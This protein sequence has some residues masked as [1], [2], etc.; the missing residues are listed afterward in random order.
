MT[1]Q[2]TDVFALSRAGTAYRAPISD[3]VTT[4]LAGLDYATVADVAAGSSATK[5]VSPAAL[6]TVVADVA[7]NAS[8]IADNV[9]SIGALMAALGDD[10][11]TGPADPTAAQGED[12]DNFLNT[13]TG[14]VFEKD[15]G[16]WTEVFSFASLLG[17]TAGANLGSGQA[18]FKGANGTVLEF[19]TLTGASGGGITV[20]LAADSDTLS[21]GL[22]IDALPVAP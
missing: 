12:G 7:R 13:S 21:F 5:V 14:T 11:L 6:T 22:D 15:G 3:L 20:A 10:Y 1:V 2:T 8:D 4:A 16:A 18:V 19:R 17:I 9:S